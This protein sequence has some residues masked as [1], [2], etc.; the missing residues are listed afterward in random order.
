MYFLS[1]YWS[2]PYHLGGEV[3]DSEIVSTKWKAF[4]W[5]IYTKFATKAVGVKNSYQLP[6][7]LSILQ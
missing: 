7:K 1:F 4:L 5:N 3:K 6:E 2:A